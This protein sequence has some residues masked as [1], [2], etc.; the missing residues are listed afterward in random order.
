MQ[1]KVTL[2]GYQPLKTSCWTPLRKRSK[3]YPSYRSYPNLTKTKNQQQQLQQG[4]QTKPNMM[5]SSSQVLVSN[6]VWV[7]GEEAVECER[8][9]YK[10]TH[11]TAS[12]HFKIF[13]EYLCFKSKVNILLVEIKDIARMKWFR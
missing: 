11:P 9:N 7:R 1:K 10:V 13:C 5:I 8:G 12:A 4:I 2:G 3:S 6:P